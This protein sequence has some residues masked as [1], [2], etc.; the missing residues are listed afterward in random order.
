MDYHDAARARSVLG[1]HEDCAAEPEFA[2]MEVL[3]YHVTAAHP[4]AHD[5]FQCLVCGNVKDDYKELKKHVEE[6]HSDLLWR[7][8]QQRMRIS[9][10]KKRPEG[11]EDAYEAFCG[12]VRRHSSKFV[13]PD[14][15][16]YG[17]FASG[18]EEDHR[19]RK[20]MDMFEYHATLPKPIPVVQAMNSGEQNV[21]TWNIEREI[22][23]ENYDENQKALEAAF[24]WLAKMEEDLKNAPAAP[25]D[26]EPTPT[27]GEPTMRRIP[28]P[29]NFRRIPEKAEVMSEICLSWMAHQFS[30]KNCKPIALSLLQAI[31]IRNGAKSTIWRTF[32]GPPPLGEPH[33]VV[34]EHEFPTSSGNLSVRPFNC[35]LTPRASNKRTP[36]KRK[37]LKNFL[38]SPFDKKKTDPETDEIV[39]A[40]IMKK[41]LFKI[42]KK[43]RNR[44][45]NTRLDYDDLV[46]AT[47]AKVSPENSRS[48]PL[49]TRKA[50]FLKVKRVRCVLGQGPTAL[51]RLSMQEPRI[52]EE[53][54]LVP[55]DARKIKREP[56]DDESTTRDDIDVLNQDANAASKDDVEVAQD[57]SHNLKPSPKRQPAHRGGRR[58]RLLF[59]LL[60]KMVPSPT[61]L[62]RIQLLCLV[63]HEPEAPR[64]DEQLPK[65][66]NGDSDYESPSTS[67]GPVVMKKAKKSATP[68]SQV[69]KVREIIPPKDSPKE[70]SPE[71]NMVVPD[72]GASVTVENGEDYHRESPAPVQSQSESKKD[73][74]T[75][76]VTI[77][78]D[79]DSNYSRGTWANRKGFVMV[80]FNESPVPRQRK[81]L[82]QGIKDDNEV[83]LLGLKQK[84]PGAGPST[85]VKKE[86]PETKDKSRVAVCLTPYQRTQL[87]S[88]MDPADPS[89]PAGPGRCR[90]CNF[91]FPRARVGR[92]HIIGH[93]RAVRVRCTLWKAGSFF[94]SEMRNHILFRHCQM[95]HLLPP[96]FITEE[97]SPAD[98]LIVDDYIEFV[99]P[100]KNGHVCFTTGKIISMS[101]MKPYY[102]GSTNRG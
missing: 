43:E 86:I 71:L 37:K 90:H 13:I 87:F 88:H 27:L 46:V 72:V 1:L 70:H 17:K 44:H 92:R 25:K 84:T 93:I 30:K 21:H 39:I 7:H 53:V 80:E 56:V 98:M 100:S 52:R 11:K 95:S 68:L 57:A 94:I 31:L 102:P 74:P 16:R 50:K 20:M 22:P 89:Q 33:I 12:N 63:A 8:K 91:E 65:W 81:Q 38:R 41:M 36:Q 19:Q 99:H 48:T 5:M 62:L 34:D 28:P 96:D 18:D 35:Q 3:A 67:Q 77:D 6:T 83:K 23:E 78:D 49:R 85:W 75:E 14:E 32:S 101:S 24:S 42:E 82:L 9:K 15:L 58:R 26:V 60:V 59:M 47:H 10:F 54:M 69:K 64:L 40:S 55:S 61:I 29:R 76:V 4:L 73:E 2:D 51:L 97:S 45:S 79:C 66:S